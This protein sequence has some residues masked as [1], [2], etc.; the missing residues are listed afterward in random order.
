M[1]SVMREI[2]AVFESF[3]CSSSERLL[4]VACEP[5]NSVLLL[6]SLQTLED[7]LD[8]NDIFLTFGH[9]FRSIEDYAAQTTSLVREQLSAVNH[10]ST[11]RG[12]IPLPDLPVELTSPSLNPM[13]QLVG[14]MQRVRTLTPIE[15]RV[16]WLFYPF[17][18]DDED[19]Y[20]RMIESL[21]EPLNDRSLSATRL[22]V[23]DRVLSPVLRPQ[24][25]AGAQV[26]WYE[27]ELD[28]QA[29]EKKLNDRANDP[30][31][32]LEEQAQLHMM[33]AGYDVAHGRF[34]QAMDRNIELLE[35]FT[36]SDGRYQQSIVMNN[37]GDL[38]Y[39][40]RRFEEAQTW[41]EKAIHLSVQLHSGP[42][43]LYQSLNLGNT[44]LTQNKFDEALIYYTAAEQLAEASGAPV[45]RIEAL[46]K[47]GIANHGIGNATEAALAWETAVD[48]SRRLRYEPGMRP[49]LERLRDLY[50]EVGNAQGHEACLTEL[51]GL[52]SIEGGN[53]HG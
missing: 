39:I 17:E 6:K 46:E 26:K 27:P 45:Q 15:R 7:A 50:W 51:A 33:L 20:Q 19:G 10:E 37:I 13:Q 3:L 22:I 40:Q 48:L 2:G 8:N 9:P 49:N 41:Y 36:D 23:R 44:L 16:L 1:K 21:I 47:S 12:D 42:L 34:D 30:C 35:Y 18:I 53:G 29:L 38:H 24:L 25:N 11:G 4:I 43:V 32:P 52:Q 14:L 5:E 31:V 28:P